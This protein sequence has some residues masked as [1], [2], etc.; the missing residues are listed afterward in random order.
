VA[1]YRAFSLGE[2]GRYIRFVELQCADDAQATKV[3]ALLEA[4]G[5]VDL[6]CGGRFVGRVGEKGLTEP[7][8]RDDNPFQAEPADP[9]PQ[10]QRPRD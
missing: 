3:A 9:D 8:P 10:D 6:W 1:Q 2:N 5:P 7:W 4:A